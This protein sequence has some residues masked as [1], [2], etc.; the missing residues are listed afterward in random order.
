[1][2]EQTQPRK[3]I[4]L[5]E[6]KYLI[7]LVGKMEWVINGHLDN[8]TKQE[9]LDLNNTKLSYQIETVVSLFPSF[10][11]LLND[12]TKAI[13]ELPEFVEVADEL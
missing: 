3:Q 11:K 2:T 4:E 5:L 12:L 13:N 1:M 9:L 8:I 6:V 10:D 7:E